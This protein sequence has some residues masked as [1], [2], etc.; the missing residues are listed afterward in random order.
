MTLLKAG[1][2]PDASKALAALGVGADMIGQT[3]GGAVASAGTHLPDGHVN[4][5]PYSCA[6][7]FHVSALSLA[8]VAKLLASLATIGYLGFYRRPGFDH[9]PPDDALHVHAIWCGAS[10]KE[11]LQGQVHDW[12]HEPMLNGLVWHQ[13]YE[14]WQPSASNREPG[15]TMYLAHNPQ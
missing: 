13:P 5:L 3:V 12:F 7:D 8:G 4:G 14:F 10:M 2:H 6:T 11:M 9:W 15:H 1:L